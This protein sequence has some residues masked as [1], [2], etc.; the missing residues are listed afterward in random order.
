[1]SQA[2][3]AFV[4]NSTGVSVAL[5]DVTEE[6]QEVGGVLGQV[7]HQLTQLLHNAPHSDNTLQCKGQRL[8][9]HAK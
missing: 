7:S 3:L 2:T 4:Y 5:E 1:M 8:L 9:C 6:Q